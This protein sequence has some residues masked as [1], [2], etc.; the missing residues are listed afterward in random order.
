[1]IDKCK[2][3][4]VK[5]GQNHTDNC[6]I[7]TKRGKPYLRYTFFCNRCGVE[8]PSTFM[9]SDKEWEEVTKYYYHPK[10][11]LCFDCFE[12]VKQIKENFF[13]DYKIDLTK[14]G[15]NQ[16]CFEDSK[17]KRLEYIQ[18][19]I[20][21]YNNYDLLDNTDFL[22]VIKILRNH[23]KWEKKEGEGIASIQV[24][25][26]KWKNKVFLLNRVDG[27]TTDISFIQAIN[28]KGITLKKRIY[29]ACRN[30][31][32]HIILEERKKIDWGNQKCPITGKILI[33]DKT[34]Q[35]DHYDLTFNE[36]FEKWLEGKDISCLEFSLNNDNEDNIVDD[37]FIHNDLKENFIDFHNK[38]THL[39]AVHYT[40]S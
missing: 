12:Y 5:E 29:N 8:K 37:F 2:Y 15:L 30:A 26:N 1:M 3:C 6:S 33:N 18:K 31:I 22:E 7:E 32:E 17:K 25:P 10:N 38:N 16:K 20:K 14:D 36:L 35:I 27:S 13:R 19:I 21:K 28:G 34:T 4:N 23:P 9:V 11:I 24:I 39:R 40:V